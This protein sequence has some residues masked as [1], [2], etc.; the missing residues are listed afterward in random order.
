MNIRIIM[1]LFLIIPMAGCRTSDLQNDSYV[2]SAN[3]TED[4]KKTNAGMIGYENQSFS[5]ASTSWYQQLWNLNTQWQRSV[6]SEPDSNGNQ[7]IQ[8]IERMSS[9][10]EGKNERKDTVYIDYK[11][12]ALLQQVVEIDN[13]LKR[14]EQMISSSHSEKK[15]EITWYQAA[16]QFL[17]ICSLLYVIVR[18]FI[19]KIP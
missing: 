13:H 14:I 2:S 1:C 16:L 3:N 4:D 15:T 11:Y 6:Y 8:A 9:V 17:G 12:E 7:Y 19:K 18:L 10:S 5:A